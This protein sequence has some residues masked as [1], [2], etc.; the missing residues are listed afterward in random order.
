MQ[1]LPLAALRA[2]AAVYEMGGVRPA[3][4][5]LRVTH[6][7]ISRHLRELERWL[8]V[9][10]FEQQGGSGRMVLTPQSQALGR[11]AVAGLSELERAVERVRESKRPNAVV[12]ATTASLAARW[13]V[14]RLP[15]LQKSQ[16]WIE[17][18]IVT[19]QS[20]RSLSEQGADL[21]L[22]MGGGPWTDEACEPLMDDA[23]FPVATRKCWSDLRE[24]NVSR[25]LARAVLLHDR[26]PSAAWEKWFAAHPAKGVDLRAGPRFTS[27]DL[28]L[29]AAAHGL[30][31]A[32]ARERLVADELATGVLFRPFGTRVLFCRAPTGSFSRFRRRTDRPYEQ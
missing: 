18:S 7:S 20:V 29:R 22:R 17:V 31:V 8:G 13:L 30:G 28:C 15:L 26:D 11:A 25:A 1:K 5:A 27:S 14:P 32:L 21:A 4:R 2:F 23:L 19:Q 24:R 12:I 6:S 16:S 3:A 10:L 9:D